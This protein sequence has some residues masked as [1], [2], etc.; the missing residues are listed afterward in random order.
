[1]RGR[2]GLD[3]MSRRILVWLTVTMVW[4]G[5]GCASPRRNAYQS[6]QPVSVSEPSEQAD[7]L[8]E[9]VQET[10]R[11]GRFQLD[12]IDRQ[13]W[14]ITTLP[15]TSQHFFEFW[16]HDVD[17][18]HDRWEATLNPMR[19]WVEVSLICADDGPWKQLAVVVHK[20]RFSSPDRQ[21][22]SSG[23]AY[24][25]FG[26]GLPSTTGKSWVTAKEDHWLDCGRDPAMEDYILR[27]ILQ[28]CHG[29][30]ASTIEPSRAP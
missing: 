15:V 28:R 30:V 6:S 10:L 27:R 23:A 16:R 29:E 26:E 11:R 5:A 9:A 25:Y 24:Q 22:N 3:P 4:C 20:E 2:Y 13:A 12:R 18:P 14:V 19:R 21:F 17:T 8:W 1:M 7:Q